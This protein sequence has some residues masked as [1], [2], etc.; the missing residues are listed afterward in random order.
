MQG[1]SRSAGAGNLALLLLHSPPLLATTHPPT[2]HNTLECAQVLLVT[3]RAK[4]SPLHPVLT[5]TPSLPPSALHHAACAQV[6]L[7]TDKAKV[8]TM[9][10][11]LSQRFSPQGLKFAQLTVSA[12]EAAALGALGVP[13]PPALLALRGDDLSKRTVYEGGQGRGLAVSW[14]ERGNALRVG[15]CAC[16]QPC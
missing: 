16:G 2:G 4:R 7:V 13:K 6:L 1:C 9:L 15:S 14:A 12:A 10:K 5:N 8:P 3:D 11:S